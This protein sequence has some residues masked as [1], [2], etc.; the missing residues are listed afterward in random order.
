MSSKKSI[1]KSIKNEIV[2]PKPLTNY[3]LNSF[4]RPDQN[5]HTSLF[6][7]LVKFNPKANTIETTLANIQ[8]LE[9][10]RIDELNRAREGSTACKEEVASANLQIE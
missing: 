8:Y 9:Q 5:V 7:S 4:E 2:Q 3:K 6:G 1:M 10:Q